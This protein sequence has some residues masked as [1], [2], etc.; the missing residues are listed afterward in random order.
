MADG[1]LSGSP[2]VAFM[3]DKESVSAHM[4]ATC[5]FRC[6]HDAP[7]HNA[8]VVF[9]S[10]KSAAVLCT[11]TQYRRVCRVMAR[12]LLQIGRQGLQYLLFPYIEGRSSRESHHFAALLLFAHHSSL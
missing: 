7:K 4:L 12:H 1:S 8:P 5:G 2:G 6:Y 11:C 9:G 3:H 10:S